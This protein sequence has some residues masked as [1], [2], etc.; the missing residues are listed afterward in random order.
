MKMKFIIPLIAFLLLAVPAL[1]VPPHRQI[2]MQVEA[3]HMVSIQKDN[4]V[5]FSG[6]VVAKQGILTIHA[7]ELTIYYVSVSGANDAPG[8]ETKE[9]KRMFARGRV[10]IVQKDWVASGDTAEYFD[11]ARKVVIVGNVKVWRDNNLVTGDRFVLFLDEGKSIVEHD[12]KKGGRVKAFFYPG[13][14]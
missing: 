5:V 1:A 14:K 8:K 11:V 7:D 4:S 2:P 3:D 6:R 9:I 13:K 12:R 10:K